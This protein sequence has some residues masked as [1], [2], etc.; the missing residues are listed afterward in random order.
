[1]DTTWIISA[2]EG[3]ARIFS[4]TDPAQAWQEVQDMVNNEARMRAD[5]Q[6]SDRLSP[7][8]AGKSAHNTGGAL[9][10]SQYEPQ[11]TP[12]V[13][14]A[15]AFAR[16]ISD[17]LVAARQAGRFDMLALVAAP[18][19]LGVLRQHLDPQLEPLVRLEIDKDYTHSSAQQLRGQI[20]AHQAQS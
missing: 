1:M 13:R 5:E 9:P 19:F 6:F 3:R 12:D 4:E 15:Q 17:Y 8:A 18:K 2:D 14:A 10:N 20:Q 11:Q 16:E 7:K